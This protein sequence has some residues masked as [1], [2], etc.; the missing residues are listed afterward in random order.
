MTPCVGLTQPRHR[1]LKYVPHYTASWDKAIKVNFIRSYFVRGRN[2]RCRK[3][4]D[5]RLGCRPLGTNLKVQPPNPPLWDRITLL[6]KIRRLA[7]HLPECRRCHG[8]RITNISPKA[9][10]PPPC[11]LKL[12]ALGREPMA[13]EG[14]PSVAHLSSFDP[15]GITIIINVIH[16]VDSYLQVI[17]TF[18]AAD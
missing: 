17:S 14:L 7:L 12:G 16:H 1:D 4:E 9:S 8:R 11:I 15:W 10:M 6:Q 2:P 3:H 5:K 13:R 18:Y